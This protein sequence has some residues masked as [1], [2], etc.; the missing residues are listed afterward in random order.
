MIMCDAKIRPLPGP[1]EIQCGLAEAHMLHEGVLEDYAYPGSH[2]V[3][4]W[5]EEDR[6]TFRGDWAPCSETTGCVL[7]AEHRGECAI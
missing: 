3:I 4:T 2:T 5:Q 7:P 6:R 1:T